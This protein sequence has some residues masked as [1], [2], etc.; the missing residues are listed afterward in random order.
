MMKCNGSSATRKVKEREE[1]PQSKLGDKLDCVHMGTHD[2]V[3]G[4]CLERR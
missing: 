4:C 1:T 3:I 2:V